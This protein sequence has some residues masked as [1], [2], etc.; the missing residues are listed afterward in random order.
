MKIL[1]AILMSSLWI[2]SNESAEDIN[3]NKF[4][5]CLSSEEMKLYEAI[6]AYRK[7]KG[8]S[9]IALST[10]LS[11]VAQTHSKDLN[12]NYQSSKRCNLH[13]WSRKGE[14]SACCYTSDHKQAECMWDKPRE[15]TDYKGDGYEIAFAK[16]K[17][18]GS[19]PELTAE[20]ALE[21]WKTSSGH[22]AVMVNKSSFKKLK[23]N[24]IGVGIYRGYATVWF[25][26]EKDE[27]TIPELCE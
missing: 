27:L 15:L 26:T 16:Y 13:S 2:S 21:G 12:D 22:N 20:E 14:W 5:V 10:S 9:E 24:A 11:L 3:V 23:W 4:E 6:N 1:F 19:D 18:D 25:G 17:S 7:T 8:L